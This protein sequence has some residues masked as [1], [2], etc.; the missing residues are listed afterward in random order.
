MLLPSRCLPPSS[1]AS[2]GTL[3]PSLSLV[4]AARDLHTVVETNDCA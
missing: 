1:S 4:R 3:V 2:A